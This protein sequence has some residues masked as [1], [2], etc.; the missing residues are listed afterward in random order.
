MEHQ[1]HFFRAIFLLITILIVYIF[2]RSLIF[3]P[4]TWIPEAKQMVRSYTPVY[5]TL[6]S[7]NSCHSEVA[8]T[9]ADGKHKGV[10][11][12][13]CHAPLSTHAEG[14]KKIAPMVRNRSAKLCMRCHQQLRARPVNFPQVVVAN[15]LSENGVAFEPEICINCHMPHSP[16][17]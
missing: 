8:K 11:C 15:H 16:T 2:M 14:K 1:K 17:L 9:K 13:V 5:G 10:L 12:E 3:H 4:D 6:D 7:C